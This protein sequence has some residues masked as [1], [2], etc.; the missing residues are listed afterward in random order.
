MSRRGL[1]LPSDML[2]SDRRPAADL[3]LVVP[4]SPSL[5]KPD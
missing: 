3:V 5:E 4:R 2:P 1:G